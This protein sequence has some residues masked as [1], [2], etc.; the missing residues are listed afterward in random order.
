MQK[1]LYDHLPS[2]MST[3][4][5]PWLDTRKARRILGLA[6]PVILAMLTQTGVNVVDTYFI[7]KLPPEVASDG[8]FA[9][10]P[11]LMFL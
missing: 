8:Q 11:S 5:T 9:L 3:E 7:G 4:R 1:R 6:G 10:T 2:R